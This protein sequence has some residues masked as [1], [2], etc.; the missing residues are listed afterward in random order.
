VTDVTRVVSDVANPSFNVSIVYSSKWGDCA[1]LATVNEKSTL[2]IEA[3][4]DPSETVPFTGWRV[5]LDK[6]A[7]LAHIDDCHVILKAM[8]KKA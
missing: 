2:R 1:Q 3:D 7:L 5:S 6:D 8:E 4:D